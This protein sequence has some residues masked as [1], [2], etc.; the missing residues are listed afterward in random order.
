MSLRPRRMFLVAATLT[1]G[2]LAFAA[3]GAATV[4]RGASVTYKGSFE[5]EGLA[6]KKTSKGCS[7]QGAFGEM[8]PGARVLISEQ[9]A[10]N[11]FSELATGKV[12]KGRFVTVDGEKV[13]RMT[14]KAKAASS[15]A[16]D[17]RV[18]LEIKGVAFSIAWPASD[19]ADGDMGIHTCEFSDDTCA[20]VVGRD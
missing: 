12:S 3:P 14:F 11:D 1:A 16:S 19:V 20:T 15:P 7:G 4:G 13:C 2:L 10:A 5:F 17:S 6:G 18:H 8:K 9:D